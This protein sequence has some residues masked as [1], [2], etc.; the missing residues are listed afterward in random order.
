MVKTATTCP[1]MTSPRR[2]RRSGP[3]ASAALLLVSVVACSN[4]AET[5]AGADG[6]DSTSATD[7]VGAST[8]DTDSGGS[9]TASADST[10]DATGTAETGGDESSGG[11][12]ECTPGAVTECYSGPPETRGVGLC[13][14]GEQE[15]GRDGAWGP[16]MG[17]AVPAVETCDT[18]GDENCDGIDPCS[19][20][21]NLL[22]SRT[23][24]G[25]ANEAGAQVGFDGSGN[26]VL[27]ARVAS[28]A[29]LGGGP[30]QS[31]GGY[32]L[33][34][35]RFAPDGGHLW[36][37]RFGDESNQW[38]NSFAL[39]VNEAGEIAATGGFAGTLDFG[40]GAL[41]SENNDMFLVRLSAQGE[42]VWSE[43]FTSEYVRPF[44]TAFDADGNVIVGGGF[45]NPLNLGGDVLSSAGAE[46]VFVGKFD[47]KGSHVWSRSYGSAESQFLRRIVT[48]GEGNCYLGGGAQ[49]TVDFGDGP[50][51]SGAQIDAFLVRL[52]AQ[53]NTEWSRRFG[54]TGIHDIN[55][56]AINP[57]GQLIVSL[58]SIGALDLGGK[59][60]DAGELRSFVARFTTDGEHAWSR[61][62][63]D[64]EVALRG[65]SVDG[66]GS[67]LLV[68]EFWG[69]SDFGGGTLTS[70]GDRDAFLVKLNESGEHVWSKRFGDDEAQQGYDVASSIAGSVAASG[71]FLGSIDLGGGL[72]TSAGEYDGF[73]AVFGP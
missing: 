42:H 21:G 13:A 47:P 51:N 1:Q 60:F 38:V 17:G 44:A 32:D 73:V 52:D 37:A 67:M 48:D 30:L 14:S 41:V 9:S 71:S 70:A 56:L 36:S 24:G 31:A 55:D 6:T 7:S 61:M 23:F 34:F 4:N 11:V 5:T 43:V 72:A 29:D 18:Q 10:S 8:G 39:A 49:G 40:G 69:E 15:C 28:V 46:D 35:A 66:V 57:A 33:F 50:L 20:D 12:G 65:V 68:G 27:A 62:V 58:E 2:S 64:G 53:G 26:L 16:C 19:G 63:G 25:E 22:W 3:R 54:T 59:S 45:E